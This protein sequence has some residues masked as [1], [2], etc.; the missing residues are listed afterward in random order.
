MTASPNGKYYST[1][2]VDSPSLE[3]SLDSKYMYTALPWKPIPLFAAPA[4]EFGNEPAEGQPRT[5]KLVPTLHRNQYC[6]IPK[7]ASFDSPES[8]NPV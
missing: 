8:F 4:W 2:P 5:F 3:R 6:A 7:T 1:N